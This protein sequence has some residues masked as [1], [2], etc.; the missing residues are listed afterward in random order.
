MPIRALG[1]RSALEIWCTDGVATAHV[2]VAVCLDHALNVAFQERQREGGQPTGFPGMLQAVFV[3][4]ELW[5]RLAPGAWLPGGDVGGEASSGKVN[6]STTYVSWKAE[7]SR[8]KV[9][10]P[11]DAWLW[12]D[13]LRD[14]AISVGA[15]GTPDWD[16]VA[17]SLEEILRALAELM[18]RGGWPLVADPGARPPPPPPPPPML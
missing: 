5:V 11:G 13:G 12:G 7:A 14:F 16:A 3:N 10:G 15:G 8:P 6:F 4:D 18:E 1:W 2:L 9:A 17:P